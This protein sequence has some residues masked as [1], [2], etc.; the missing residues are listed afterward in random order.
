MKLLFRHSVKQRRLLIRLR[1][2]EVATYSCRASKT[3]N[4]KKQQPAN[5][6]AVP[7]AAPDAVGEKNYGHLFTGLIGHGVIWSPVTK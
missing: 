5:T 6:G 7:D 4:R 1:A 2:A 3:L